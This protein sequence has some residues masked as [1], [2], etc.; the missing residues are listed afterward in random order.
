VR[1]RIIRTIL[2]ASL[3]AVVT[4]SAQAVSEPNDATPDPQFI[5]AQIRK[6]LD[7]IT[8][9]RCTQI[10]LDNRSRAGRNRTVPVR[11][12]KTYIAYDNQGRGRVRELHDNLGA[13]TTIW[14]GTRSIE[15]REHVKPNGAVVCT[16]SIVPGEYPRVK[17]SNRPW[18]SLRGNL[19]HGLAQNIEAG[20]GACVELTKDGHYRLEIDTGSSM[21]TVVHLDPRRGYLPIR[22]EMYRN[23]EPYRRSKIEF[24][25]VK[26]GI[27]FPTVVLTDPT[28]PGRTLSGHLVPRRRFTN[29]VVNDPDFEHQ[30]VPALPD[31]STVA[32]EV[33]GLRYVVD[34]KRG[35]TIDG[36]GTSP[37][38]TEQPVS[39]DVALETLAAV[40]SLDANELLKRVGPAIPSAWR[41]F[42]MG[43]EAHQAS[44]AA[45]L[46]TIY[47]LQWGDKPQPEVRYT[48]T[49]FLKLSEVLQYVCGLGIAEY[50]GAE[51]LLELRLRGDWVVRQDAPIEE[52]LRVLERIVL[53]ETGRS[54]T[55]KK[56]RVDTPV[57]RATGIFQYNALPGASREN[58]IHLF[59]A[60]PG[61]SPSYE[62]SGS[63]SLSQL[64]GHV[65]NRT[66]R[67]FLD[68]TLSSDVDVSWSDDR[69][70]RVKAHRN[71]RQKYNYYLD[72]LLEK[73]AQQ[74]GLKLT[75]ERRVIDEWR[76]ELKR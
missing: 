31:G 18:Y 29:I 49:G 37:I 23:G 11:P 2:A 34:H 54:A 36:D 61:H 58:H 65:A 3:W 64:L 63:G 55:F 62:G 39:R 24:K 27:W 56:Q 8:N 38:G 32:D 19:L 75:K 47:V 40:Y 69:T 33:R 73:L 53:E 20:S 15:V 67:R 48:G 4:A 68:D 13:T 30:L 35:F 1:G 44:E 76:V 6:R 28:T 7:A 26:P 25:E 52:C 74:T 72:K 21:V 17:R 14:D 42:G 51:E 57:V 5:L 70:S 22:E 71:P 12:T 10:T 45:L 9:Y 50:S 60:V 66:G 43:G 41:P 59:V 16:A 46:N